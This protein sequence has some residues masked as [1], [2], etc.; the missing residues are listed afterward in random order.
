MSDKDAF[1]W[2]A[3]LGCQAVMHVF[4]CSFWSSVT[5]CLCDFCRALSSC[6]RAPYGLLPEVCYSPHNMTSRSFSRP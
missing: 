4:Q 6:H 1:A 2:P 5:C 3:W